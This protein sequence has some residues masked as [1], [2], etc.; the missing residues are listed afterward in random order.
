MF[1]QFLNIKTVFMH[2]IIPH[3]KYLDRL[4][5]LLHKYINDE[6][7]NTLKLSYSKYHI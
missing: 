3:I 4:K 5:Y 1:I 6:I 7:Y 2:N